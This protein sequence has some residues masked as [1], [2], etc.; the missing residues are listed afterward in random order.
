M[1]TGDKKRKR[2]EH[3]TNEKLMDS[4]SA[5][6][7]AWQEARVDDAC[8]EVH[9]LKTVGKNEMGNMNKM[10]KRLFWGVRE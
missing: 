2:H 1:I 8:T 4:L 6:V 10:S 7:T 5:E 3:I 9:K